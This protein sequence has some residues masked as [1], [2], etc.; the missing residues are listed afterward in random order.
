MSSVKESKIRDEVLQKKLSEM[1]TPI[2]DKDR[3]KLEKA[4]KDVFE[5]G[6]SFQEALGLDD[7]NVEAIYE[8][9]QQLYNAGDYSKAVMFFTPL[10]FVADKEKSGRY[11][12]GLGASYHMLKEYERAILCYRTS[13]MVNRDDPMAHYHLVDCYMQT[14][15]MTSAYLNCTKT[16]ELAKDNPKYGMIVTSAQAMAEKLKACPVRL[17]GFMYDEQGNTVG[18]DGI[19]FKDLHKMLYGEE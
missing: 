10:C 18:M 4:L 7:S 1:E 15:E 11:W 17:K 14:G 5:K 12:F 16:I 2:S 6:K 9:A 3:E 19:L 8:H 13:S